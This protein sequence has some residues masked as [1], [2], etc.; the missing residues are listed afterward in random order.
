MNIFFNQISQYFQAG[1]N[2]R[3]NNIKYSGGRIAGD[4]KAVCDDKLRAES[5]IR[6]F[7][8]CSNCI[9]LC[10]EVN[11]KKSDRYFSLRP[12]ESNIADNKYVSTVI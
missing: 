11:S 9:C 5:W 8:K 1:K 10:D 4:S 3:Y 2:R 12:V 6:W 7:V